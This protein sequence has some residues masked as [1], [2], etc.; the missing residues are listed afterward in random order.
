[1]RRL[2][3]ERRIDALSDAL[4]TSHKK[5]PNKR[6]HTLRLPSFKDGWNGDEG[7]DAAVRRDIERAGSTVVRVRGR[8][9]V[10]EQQEA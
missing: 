8:S 5:A 7:V 10:I 2:A 4:R 6:R 3:A 9:W 1:M